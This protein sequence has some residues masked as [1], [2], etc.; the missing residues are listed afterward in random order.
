MPG[1]VNKD[2]NASKEKNEFINE[3]PANL[4]NSFKVTLNFPQY[5]TINPM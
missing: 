2:L 4:L 5:S 3:C 1:K